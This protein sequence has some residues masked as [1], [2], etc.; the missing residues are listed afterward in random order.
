MKD[1][2]SNDEC[3]DESDVVGNDNVEMAL[4]IFKLLFLT[5]GFALPIFAGVFSV[6]SMLQ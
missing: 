6:F 3:L 4:A 1:Q 2:Y 5:I